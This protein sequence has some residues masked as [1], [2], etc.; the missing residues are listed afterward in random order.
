MFRVC[1]VTMNLAKTTTTNYDMT[2]GLTKVFKGN[3]THNPVATLTTG[4]FGL[5]AGNANNDGFV[6]MT[7][8]T[9]GNNDYLKLL[10]TRGSSIASQTGVYSS[11]DLN[12]DGNVKMTGLTPANNDYLRLLN[13]LGSSTS[14]LTQPGF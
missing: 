2:N 12:L 1:S 9:T 10:N 14:S 5:W 6:K 11:Q 4:V 13:T 7:G 3:I 8:L